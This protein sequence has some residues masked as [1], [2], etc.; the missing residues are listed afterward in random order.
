MLDHIHHRLER[1]R[2]LRLELRENLHRIHHYA[3]DTLNDRAV[4]LV[5]CS[6]PCGLANLVDDPLL[7]AKQFLL[8]AGDDVV[9]GVE[10]QSWRIHAVDASRPFQTV[11]S[12]RSLKYD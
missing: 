5:D 7:R 6:H 4:L 2:V 8:V 10:R 1:D 9:G 12:G 11:S 3:P